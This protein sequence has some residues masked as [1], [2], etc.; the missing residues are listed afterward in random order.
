MDDDNGAVLLELLDSFINVN[1]LLVKALYSSF[2][3]YIYISNVGT[4]S[5]ESNI[6]LPPTTFCC[7]FKT[8]VVCVETGKLSEKSY[9]K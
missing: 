6:I 3:R 8:I 1:S 2:A 9:Q 4:F 7:T 5:P